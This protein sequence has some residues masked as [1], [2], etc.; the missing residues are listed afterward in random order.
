MGSGR[1]PWSRKRDI[2]ELSD[3][4]PPLPPPPLPPPEFESS[5]T[6][7]TVGNQQ[8]T[9]IEYGV[10]LTVTVTVTGPAPDTTRYVTW[11]WPRSAPDPTGPAMPPSAA[12]AVAPG[13]DM[14]LRDVPEPDLP[15]PGRHDWPVAAA[16]A[17]LG[18][19]E[20][21]VWSDEDTDH[22]RTAITDDVDAY[23]RSLID[24]W[25]GLWWQQTW[26]TK[27][28]AR[29]PAFVADLEARHR[30]DA[31]FARKREAHRAKWLESACT[32]GLWE[33]Y[34][35]RHPWPDYAAQDCVVCGR[36]FAPEGLWASELGFGPPLACKACCRRAMSGHQL[37]T[38]DVRG[39]LSTFAATLGFPPPSSYRGNRELVAVSP[40]RTELL[41]LLVALPDASTCAEV[42]GVPPGPG[43][44]LMV[45][46]H[47]GIVGEACKMPR[48]VMTIASDGHLC[49]SLGELAIENYLIANDIAH[50][51]EP[52][53]P[54]HPELNP[55][56]GQR[57]DWLLPGD[58]WIEYAGMMDAAE[59]ATKMAVKVQLAAE[60]GLDLLVLTPDDLPRLSEVIEA[61][62][63]P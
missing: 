21:D 17:E 34:R 43:R 31:R 18:F 41:V 30:A 52:K 46:Q 40:H 58:R 36:A 39:L 14:V 6:T 35:E 22:V 11:D 23:M 48:G 7:E 54:T 50:Q 59:Y 60:C 38:L 62:T 26:D 24:R 53:Y 5:Q 63:A 15:A 16:L 19:G 2:E 13:L 12:L 32:I 44:W 29:F 25:K 47:C 4:P 1:W 51:P 49:R 3:A 8:I 57:A 28:R 56:G 42:L 9:T 45:L 37:T 20:S 33:V 27:F 10:G 55:N 61:P